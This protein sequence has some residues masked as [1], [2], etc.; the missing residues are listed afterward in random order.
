ML[1]VERERKPKFCCAGWCWLWRWGD[2]EH[3]EVLS[4]Q[5]LSSPLHH[6]R[7][8]SQ[9]PAHHPLWSPTWYGSQLFSLDNRR[10]T[11]EKFFC[12]EYSQF[13]ILDYTPPCW[14]SDHSDWLLTSTEPAWP[15]VSWNSLISSEQERG[16]RR[17]GWGERRVGRGVRGQSS[18]DW[19]YTT[20]TI[21]G[22]G[23]GSVGVWVL[24]RTWSVDLI[25]VKL[26]ILSPQHIS[27]GWRW[28][29]GVL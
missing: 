21:L 9:D 18:P 19:C 12:W 4:W 2:T 25:S 8:P 13:D 3:H 24:Q 6:V 22:S 14:Q 1:L 29:P 10:P 23:S 11:G 20:R 28:W 26:I 17:E 5:L 15:S 27:I 16:R 7:N